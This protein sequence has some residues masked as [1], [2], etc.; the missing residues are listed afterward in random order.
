M[1]CDITAHIEWNNEGDWEHFAEVFL[2]RWYVAFGLLAGVRGE[3]A[4]FTP[5]GLP[6]NLSDEV[7][8]ERED[9][10][11]HSDSWLSTADMMQVV[12]R[13]EA[14]GEGIEYKA[15]LAAM[16]ALGEARLVFWFDS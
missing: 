14:Y 15:T 4:L 11:G 2:P 5:R 16:V 6:E 1:G 7:R 9:C 12:E 8:E 13:L 3:D 10:D